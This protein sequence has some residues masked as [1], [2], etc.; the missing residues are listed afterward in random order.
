MTSVE[1]CLQSAYH[2]A[3]EQWFHLI[4]EPDH[5]HLYIHLVA[6]CRSAGAITGHTTAPLLPADHCSHRC[7]SRLYPWCRLHWLVISNKQVY[8][9]I[10]SYCIWCFCKYVDVIILVTAEL[11]VPGQ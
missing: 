11:T 1:L 5:I 10:C 3:D 6:R 7:S 8:S 9:E 4:V 2:P